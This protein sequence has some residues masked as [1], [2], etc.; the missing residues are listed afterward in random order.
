MLSFVLESGQIVILHDGA[1]EMRKEEFDHTA[2]LISPDQR[3]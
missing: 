1:R 3:K 2:L